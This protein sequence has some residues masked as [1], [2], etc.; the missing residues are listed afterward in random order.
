MP[1]TTFDLQAV[2]KVSETP[3]ANTGLLAANNP[4]TISAM[5][6]LGVSLGPGTTPAVTAAALQTFSFTAGAVT[7]D[8]TSLTG[9]NG[10]AVSLSALKGRGVVIYNPVGNASITV[11]KGASNGYTGLGSAFSIVIPAGGWFVFYDGGNGVAV[12]G[13]DKT[14]DVTGSGVQSFYAGLAGGA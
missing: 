12:S 14:L 3:S 11:A 2:F 13:S 7:I 10:A 4:P 1:I 6:N 8:L 9:M 5:P